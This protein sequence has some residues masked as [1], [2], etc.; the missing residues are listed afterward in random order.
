MLRKYLPNILLYDVKAG[1]HLRDEMSGGN[2]TRSLCDPYA[3]SQIARS[4]DLMRT[5]AITVRS[6]RRSTRENFQK[7]CN[8]KNRYPTR[9]GAVR[10]A[11][12]HQIA[13]DRDSFCLLLI[14]IQADRVSAFNFI[15]FHVLQLIVPWSLIAPHRH[16][17][18]DR[19]RCDRALNHLRKKNFQNIC[20]KL[21]SNHNNGKLYT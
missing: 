21:F 15:C 3:I 19:R 10:F 7:N 5:W 6:A 12:P 17:S 2:Q 8:R 14:G 11:Q 20:E 4:Y 1:L 16:R 13:C 9:A 18:S